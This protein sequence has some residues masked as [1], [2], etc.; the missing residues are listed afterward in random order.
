MIKYKLS[1]QNNI[2]LLSP[3]F[4]SSVLT[5]IKFLQRKDPKHPKVVKIKRIEEKVLAKIVDVE[6]IKQKK[7]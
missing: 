5:L 6:K 1:T 7:K 4:K 3:Q 2:D